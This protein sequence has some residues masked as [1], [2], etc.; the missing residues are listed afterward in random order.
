MSHDRRFY[1]LRLDADI[2]L[3][4]ACTAVL[5]EALNEGNVAAVSFVNLRSIPLAEAVGADALVAQIIADDGKLFLYGSLADGENALCRLDAAAKA[6]VLNI[7]L[8]DE[9]DCE[10]ALLACLLFGYLQSVSVP[11]PDDI[12][13]PQPENIADAQAQIALQ[14]KRR[15]YALIRSAAAEAL[16]HRLNYL[17]VLLCRERYGFLIHNALQS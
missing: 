15:R 8:N 7:L 9:R 16:L 14:H 6:V 13:K 4:R 5:Q 1:S 10:N 11:I 12:A 3:C 17:A 2:A